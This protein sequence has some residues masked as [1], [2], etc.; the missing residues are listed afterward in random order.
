M[1]EKNPFNQNPYEVFHQRFKDIDK[2]RKEVDAHTFAFRDEFMKVFIPDQTE[3]DALKDQAKLLQKSKAPQQD[4]D[5]IYYKM[6]LIF[7][8]WS[9]IEEQLYEMNPLYRDLFKGLKSLLKE[10]EEKDKPKKK[11]KKSSL[12]LTDKS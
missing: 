9:P 4:L 11:S 3:F 5:K 1:K 2:L 6:A 12:D 8:K 10:I 7:K